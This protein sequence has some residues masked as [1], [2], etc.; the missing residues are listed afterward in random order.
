MSRKLDYIFI[1]TLILQI[2]ILTYI[3][4]IKG[5]TLVPTHFNI[6]GEADGYGNSLL[7]YCLIIVNVV[8]YM[9]FAFLA[10]RLNIQA[11][12][13]KAYKDEEERQRIEHNI[14][15]KIKVLFRGIGISFSIPLTLII[16]TIGLSLYIETNL[17]GSILLY[18]LVLYVFF[19]FIFSIYSVK[20]WKKEFL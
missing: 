1:V 9:F 17:A 5:N 19:V 7:Y 20:W 3:V 4:V 13:F 2:G 11:E 8:V 12:T 18:S 6:K 14:R 10:K 15:T 16:A